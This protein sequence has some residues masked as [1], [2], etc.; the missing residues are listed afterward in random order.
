MVS[1][2]EAFRAESSVARAVV[3]TKM[4][5][6]PGWSKGTPRPYARN[7]PAIPSAQAVM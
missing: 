6:H 2:G 7:S 5:A 4:V 1:R 3:P